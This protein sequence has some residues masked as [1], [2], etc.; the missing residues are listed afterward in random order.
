M[1][2]YFIMTL[3]I[4]LFGACMHA[5]RSARN[6]RLFLSF[7]FG[8]MILV[9]SLRAPSVGID[10]AVHYAKNCRLQLDANSKIFDFFD[11]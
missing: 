5:N 7:S 10:L 6:K 1:L 9:A 8:L 2:I 11:V 4:A 3:I